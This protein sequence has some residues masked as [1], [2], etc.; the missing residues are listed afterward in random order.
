M[1]GENLESGKE[2]KMIVITILGLYLLGFFISF[3]L[4]ATGLRI[5][6]EPAPCE[7]ALSLAVGSWL[8]AITGLIVVLSIAFKRWFE[9]LGDE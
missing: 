2:R 3:C 9:W 4:F 8:T 5:M 1:D 6:R 7:R